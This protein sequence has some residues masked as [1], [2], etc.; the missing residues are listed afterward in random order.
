MNPDYESENTHDL[1]SPLAKAVEAVLAEPLPDS[2]AAR[3]ILKARQLDS[4]DQML[5]PHSHVAPQRSFLIW[6]AAGAVAI[7]ATL[8][9]ALFLH[10]G[11]NNSFA[12]ML[13]AVKNVPWIHGTMTVTLANGEK[14]GTAEFWKST[15]PRTAASKFGEEMHFVDF[16]KSFSLQYD[17][18]EG[19]IYRLPSLST[20]IPMRFGGPQLPELLERLIAD[21]SDSRGLFHDDR[22]LEVKRRTVEENGVSRL[23]Y[24]LSLER[25]S[26][27]TLKRKLRILLDPTTQLPDV[28]EEELSNGQRA[29]T[30]F[31]YPDSG[32]QSLYEL[33]APK[34]ARI[35]DRIPKGDLARMIAAQAADRTHFE[36]YDAIVVQLAEKAPTDYFNLMNPRAYCVRRKGYRYRVDQFLTPK[37]RFVSPGADA[38]MQQ[39]WKEN[40]DNYWSVPIL[41]CDGASQYYYQMV[42]DAL[43]PG[44]KPNL[45]VKETNQI[46]VQQT[47]DTRV[48]WPFLMPEFCS[49]PHIGAS[50]MAEVAVEPEANDGPEGA[51][52]III[53]SN[54]EPPR[55]GELYRYWFDPSRDYVLLKQVAKVFD[56][57]KLE[58]VTTEEFDEFTQSPSGKW[59]PRAVRRVDSNAPENP[60]TTRFYVNFDADLDDA[61]FQRIAKP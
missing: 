24:T 43:A 16:E 41:I 52:R 40:R 59:Y 28:W 38:D 9:L 27:A 33:G 47:P 51:V 14:Y 8:A 23:E 58:F 1:E 13:A 15:S 31:D 56:A 4:S 25:I 37:E 61:L 53:S 45:N 49:R 6:G 7:A 44:K 26:N 34:T 39:W 20:G 29:L 36:A 3:V 5:S 22:V 42:D 55:S 35:I 12:E 17:A 21:K 10:P 32:P 18:K 48:P 50:K 30:K 46:P 2:A 54:M 19:A 57:T 11:A 60:S